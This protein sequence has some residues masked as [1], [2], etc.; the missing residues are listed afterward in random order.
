MNK[1]TPMI[2]A[3]LLGAFVLQAADDKSGYTFF[4]PTP[5][6]KMRELST[7][8][9]D[10]TESAYTVDAGHFQIEAD[11]I[12]LSRDH[13]TADGADVKARSTTFANLNL[14]AGLT[15]NID[16]QFVVESFTT[17]K[18]TDRTVTPNTTDKASGFGDITTRLK[19]NFWGNDGGETA[20]ALMPYVKFPTN[21]DNL[22]ND[23]IEG[24]LI[25][26]YALTLPGGWGCGLMPQIDIVRDADDS[27]YHAEFVFSATV[28]HDISGK[29]G[30]Y[31]ELWASRSTES[32]AK[33]VATF[34]CGLTYA[35]SDDIQ[36]D[37]GA[38]IG[39]TD[40]A[41]DFAP[42]LGLSMRF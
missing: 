22:G 15:N 7:D 2:A 13:D 35:I 20:F 9:P 29:L 23:D 11:L 10:K 6:E 4:N 34:D 26:P 37:L 12:S 16:L 36:L 14:K 31:L 17:A 41:D 42:F 40:A 27:G 1:S 3:L 38:N 21:Q 28:S 33:T 25:A 8:R 39:I 24:G 30:G 5:R 18:S 32:G 19:I